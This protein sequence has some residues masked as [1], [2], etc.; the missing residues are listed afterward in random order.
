[1]KN[2]IK[3]GVLLLCLASA[4]AKGQDKQLDSLNNAIKLT[5]NRFGKICSPE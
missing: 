1:M 5:K 3:V 4:P 2:F